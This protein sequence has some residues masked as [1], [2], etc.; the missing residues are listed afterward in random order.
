MYL[1]VRGSQ[2]QQPRDWYIAAVIAATIGAACK[3][4]IAV[5]PLVMALYDRAFL[6]ATWREVWQKR[7]PLYLGLLIPVVF[8]LYSTRNLLI[9]DEVT[10]AGFAMKDVTAWEYLRSQPGVILHYLRLAVW[11]DRLI[12]DY[13]WP[14]AELPL[15]IY[16]LGAIIV[17]LVGGSLWAMWRHPRIGFLA[18]AFFL[19][20]APT[21]SIMPIKDLA[22]E[23]RMYL[24]LAAIAVLVVVAADWLL[25]RLPLGDSLQ[26][27][28][29]LVLVAVVAG[30]LGLRTL[31]RNRD[32]GDSVVIW[33][34]CIENNPDHPRPYRIL[35][36]VFQKADPHLAIDFY[37]Q[38]LA[39][40]PRIYW[41][42]VDLGNA[43]LKR[44][45]VEE[46]IVAYE[47]AV[48]LEPRVATAHLNLS[49]LRMRTGDYAG[50]VAAAQCA[51]SVEPHDP[52][53]QKQLA[54]LLAT[55]DD[56]AVRDGQ[57]AIAILGKLPQDPQ[58]I[59]IQYLEVLSAA[60]AEVGQFDEAIS[61]A[62]KALAEARK[63]HSRRIGEFEQRV[64]LYQS[65]QPFRTR[66]NVT[67]GVSAQ[68]KL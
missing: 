68:A 63:M 39:K 25:R 60:Y 57:Q 7:W 53:G 40:N 50:A 18:L 24:P 30:L 10:A 2:S 28:A 49:R 26:G 23:H 31:G 47:R 44:G 33:K 6:S 22:F 27:Q 11:P 61:A 21:S 52:V 66:A 37:Q 38:A 12:L 41:L 48:E 13:G 51:V 20:L 32:Y 29:A 43:Q 19:I 56:A 35:A 3:E 9:G 15:A 5:V 36:D 58:R 62:E 8:V 34:Q 59:D 16:G 64:Q 45:R 55:A 42:W 67:V 4:V 54:W 14:V 17:A 1:A 65:Q 46:A